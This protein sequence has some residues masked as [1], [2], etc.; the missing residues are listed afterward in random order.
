M[1][2]S[3]K[4]EKKESPVLYQ[5]PTDAATK[6]IPFEW[7][8]FTLR[9]VKEVARVK[10]IVAKELEQLTVKLTWTGARGDIDNPTGILSE[11]G[12]ECRIVDFEFLNAADGWLESEGAKPRVIECDAINQKVNDRFQAENQISIIWVLISSFNKKGIIIL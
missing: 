7:R 1:A 3:F 12:A 11:L 2:H 5:R 8:W 9:E 4:G 10:C 6:L